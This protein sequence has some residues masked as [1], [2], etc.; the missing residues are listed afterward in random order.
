MNE[1]PFNPT[2]QAYRVSSWSLPLGYNLDAA[3][4]GARLEPDASLVGPVAEPSGPTL[5]QTQP[6]V[7]IFHLARDFTAYEAIGHTRWLFRRQWGLP[8]TEV[9]S[10]EVVGALDDIDVLVVP[11]GG[12][13]EGLRK[14]GKAGQRALIRWMN[15]GGRMIAWRYGAARLAYAL[16]VSQARYDMVP[17]SIDGPMLKALV[18]ADTP[19]GKGVGPKVWALVDTAAMRAPARFSPIRFPTIESG[20]FR[21]SGV[22][23]STHWLQGT[24]AVSDEPVGRGRCVVFSF[25][26]LYGGGSEGTQKVLFNA[27]FG[28]D[29]EGFGHAAPVR[30]DAEAIQ[31]RWDATTDWVDPPDPDVH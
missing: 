24:T 28:P 15:D 20:K 27:I 7:A 11:A 14:L 21:V 3:M 31:R 13:N 19:L 23:R 2:N 5:P 16:G 29:P 17:G 9:N 18:D 10:D 25:D 1:D 12:I 30:Y 6:R 8:F 4:S 26:P 22:R